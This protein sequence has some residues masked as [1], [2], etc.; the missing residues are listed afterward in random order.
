M[1]NALTGEG[2]SIVFDI[3]EDGVF[4][5]PD[6]GSVTYT[7]RDNSGQGIIGH[8]S[9]PVTTVEGQTTVMLTL[10][11]GINTKSK[12]FELRTVELTYTVGGRNGKTRQSYR[13]HD[14]M[15]YS[16][17]QSDVRAFVG[18]SEAELPDHEVDLV[19]AYLTLK[20]DLADLDDHLTSGDLSA[21]RA[22]RAIVCTAVLSLAHTIQLRAMHSQSS[23]TARVAR[24]T[25]I[26]WNRVT[27]QASSELSELNKV[28]TNS[29][30]ASVPLLTISTGIDPITG[31]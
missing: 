30:E 12:T 17:S 31:A 3:I 24:Y 22:N 11:G 29:L 16:V 26:D 2:V 19:V 27:H 4:V 5:S 9:Q 7:V 28:L 15:P 8:T 1:L 13:V 23:E 6:V 21:I 14:W 25:N 10:P 18:L 20:E